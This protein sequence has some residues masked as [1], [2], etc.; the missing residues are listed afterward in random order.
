MVDCLNLPAGEVV[1]STCR[2]VRVP[3]RPT[4]S[5]LGTPEMLAAAAVGAAV[6]QTAARVLEDRWLQFIRDC[7][8][9]EPPSGWTYLGGDVTDCYYSAGADD[10]VW[11]G[12]DWFAGTTIGDDDTYNGAA[13]PYRN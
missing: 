11:I 3:V 7:G 2:P 9:D 1:P 5:P 8:S 6:D 12:A 13:L 4:P 10:L